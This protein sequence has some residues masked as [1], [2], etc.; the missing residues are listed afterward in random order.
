[1]NIRPYESPA[2]ITTVQFQQ[3]YNLT[4]D[5]SMHGSLIDTN[6]QYLPANFGTNAREIT[7]DD[8]AFQ[9]HLNYSP[10]SPQIQIDP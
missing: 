9:M 5:L 6:R 3:E 4:V 7:T 1:M 8:C 10:Q 2:R